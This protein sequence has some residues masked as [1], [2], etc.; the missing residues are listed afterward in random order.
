LEAGKMRKETVTIRL[1][2][3]TKAQAEDLFND[4]GMSMSSAVIIFLR[5]AV[6]KGVSLS[7]SNAKRALD[8]RSN[9]S[10]NPS[11]CPSPYEKEPLLMGRKTIKKRLFIRKPLVI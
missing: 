1:D 7:K 10:I 2:P 11:N 6:R 3:E 4:L 8:G 9:P 5:Q